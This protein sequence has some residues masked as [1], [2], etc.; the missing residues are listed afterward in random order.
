[1]QDQRRQEYLAQQKLNIRIKVRI[2]FRLRNNIEKCKFSRPCVSAGSAVTSCAKPLEEV[3]GAGITVSAG[4]ADGG[5]IS[6]GCK[7]C[8]V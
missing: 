4:T 5:S 3:S 7:G 6:G 2:C 8:V 1:M